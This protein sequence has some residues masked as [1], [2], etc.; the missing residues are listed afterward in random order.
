MT[1][2]PTINLLLLTFGQKTEHH[3]QAAFSI[4]SFLKEP[5]INKVIIITD[6]PDFYD[7]LGDRVECICVSETKCKQWQGPH[8]FFWRVKIKALEFAQ[9]KYPND[10]LLY[11]DSDTF[12]AGNL[13]A[14]YQSLENGYSAMHKQEYLFSSVKNTSNTER[15][16]FSVLN[17]KCFSS[18]H[19]NE[20]CAMWNAGVI[21]LPKDKAKELIS[22]SI[23][24]CDEI[25]E[26]KCPRRLVEQLSFSL[27]LSHLAKLLPCDAFIG[28]YWGNKSE[29]NQHIN[30]FFAD[31]FLK[32]K[33]VDIL[34]EEL[35]EF[36]WSSLPI[37]KKER[38]TNE[39][40]CKLID[41]LFPPKHIQFFN[42]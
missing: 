42:S 1:S 35:K 15:K 14:L 36:D 41:R 3:S 26:T 33:S 10:H 38:S 2:K 12:L 13:T 4:L 30:L 39:K 5:L 19:I 16:M 9:E 25:C 11:V 23:L 7:F 34:I 31:A 6:R 17:G 8:Q 24:I 27:A 21:A 29:W 18:I 32:N 22:L 20:L 40:L 28:H 37:I